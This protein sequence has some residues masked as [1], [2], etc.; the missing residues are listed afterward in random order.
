MRVKTLNLFQFRNLSDGLLEFDPAVNFITGDNGQ[1]KTNLLEAISFLSLAK[2]FRTSTM[3][4]VTRWNQTS[5]SVFGRVDQAVSEIELGVTVTEGKRKVFLNQDP[6][7]SLTEYMGKLVTVTFSPADLSLV[8][9][10]PAGRRLFLDKHVVDA[11]PGVLKKLMGYNRALKNKNALLRDRS[12]SHEL[13]EPWNILMSECAPAILAS[14]IRFVSDMSARADRYYQL[15]SGGRDGQLQTCYSASVSRGSESNGQYLEFLRQVSSRELRAG[16]SLYGP[17]RD[18][19]QILLNDREAKSS[20]SQGQARSIVLSL[21]LAVV[22]MIEAARGDAPV[23]LLDD[24]ESELDR[25][26]VESLLSLIFSGS[27]QV[28]LTGTELALRGLFDDQRFGLFR[29]SNGLVT[30]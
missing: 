1:G 9:G 17:H 4:E 13:I 21:K 22:D 7:S 23:I 14:R 5:C 2:S 10:A 20:A 16:A 11:S 15:L 30:S 18:E 12:V 3:K 27:R 24:V 28:F 8:Q 29:V 19:L 26:R 6:V 25:S